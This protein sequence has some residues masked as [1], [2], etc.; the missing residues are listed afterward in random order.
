MSKLT[1]FDPTQTTMLRKAFVGEMQRRLREVIAA[2]VKMVVEEDAFGLVKPVLPRGVAFFAIN[3]GSKPFQF[4]SNPDKLVDFTKWLKDMVDSK[5]LGIENGVDPKK[6]WLSKYIDSAYKKGTIKT[7]MDAY[8]LQLPKLEPGLA[9]TKKSFLESSFG[10]PITTQRLQMI[11]TRDFEQ[12]KAISAQMSSNISRELAK[13]LAN[14]QGPRQIA[15]NLAKEVSDLGKKRAV[16]M[17]RTEIIHAY[18]EGQLDAFEDLGIDELEM[19]VEFSS[20]GDDR[21]C[22]RCLALSGKI[23]TV[24]EARGII[25][26]HPQC[27][28][29]WIPH[30]KARTRGKPTMRDRMNKRMNSGGTKRK[31]S[32]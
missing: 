15:S 9:V 27:R 6:P 26:V 3:A 12:L 14:G 16:V 31:V 20:A 23:Y 18:A 13:G 4:S 11:Y 32:V 30:M 28:C 17:A 8:K 29:A 10:G 1:R 21:V 2:I 24:K 19:D 25:P 5:L 7:Y 22:P